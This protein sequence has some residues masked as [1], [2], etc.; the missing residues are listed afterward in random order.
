MKN[1]KGISA[2]VATVLII[3]ITIAAVAIVWQIVQPMIT[4]SLG[5]AS[6]CVAVNTNGVKVLDDYTCINST[7]TNHTVSVQVERGVGD[8]K[9]VGL[10][11]S[12]LNNGNTIN[13][14][15]KT[16]VP[17][18]GGTKVYKI[19]IGSKSATQVEVVPTIQVN[20]KAN[21]TCSPS[22]VVNLVPCVS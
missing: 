9:L 20:N 4:S 8:F 12:I 10:R 5:S 11:V 6:N 7:G 16:S 18:A 3:L 14:T 19:G 13:E 22:N 17:L 2:V 15:E 1:K 21:A